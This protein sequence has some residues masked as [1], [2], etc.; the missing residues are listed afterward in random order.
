MDPAIKKLRDRLIPQVNTR[1]KMVQHEEI[2]QR[3]FTQYLSLKHP[4]L[5][6][7]AIP[8]GGNRDAKV[9]AQLRSTGVKAGVFDYCFLWDGGKVAYIE[10]KAGKNNMQANQRDFGVML[11]DCGIPWAVCYSVDEAITQ[12]EIW[13]AI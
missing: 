9:G 6:A 12:L 11:D 1:K 7:F 2:I 5:L 13:G 10:F 4:K 3:A 8:N